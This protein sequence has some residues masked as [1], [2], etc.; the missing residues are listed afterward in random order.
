MYLSLQQVE[1]E[2]D[3]Y[4][5]LCD[6]VGIDK[7]NGYRLT[8]ALKKQRL[9]LLIDEVEKM[10]GKGFTHNL[11]DLL[12]SLAEGSD[13]PLRLI[14]AAREP[15]D[16]LFEEGKTSPL[17]NICIEINLVEWDEYTARAFIHSRLDGTNV[18]FTAAEISHL[19]TD[20]RGHPQKLM[21]QCHKIYASYR[22]SPQ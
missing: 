17:A 2:A 21:E 6:E 9:L 20:S 3:F 1:N 8:R 10:A 11:R 18:R 7:C 14:M 5:Y 19:I 15:L 13:A 4:W 12:R 22:D 16:T